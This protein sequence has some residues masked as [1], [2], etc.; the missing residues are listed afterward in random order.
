MPR[1]TTKDQLLSDIYKERQALEQ[2]L[3]TL[4]PE[5]MTLEGIVGFWAVK[6]VL[7][8]LLEWEQMVLGWYG[9]G[10][11]GEPPHVPAEVSIG[12]SCHSSTSP[13]T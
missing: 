8:H 2:F 5:Q 10:L 9:A 13:S 12:A 4:S 7:A 6:D 3:A 11:R 1:P